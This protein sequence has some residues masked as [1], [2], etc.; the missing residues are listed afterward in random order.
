MHSLIFVCTNSKTVHWTQDTAIKNIEAQLN[1]SHSEP[2]SWSQV[3]ETFDME[4]E[5]GS[6][7]DVSKLDTCVTVVDASNLDLNLK[8]IEKVKVRPAE[9]KCSYARNRS[10][11]WALMQLTEFMTMN[12]ATMSKS[13]RKDM[14]QSSALLHPFDA[15]TIP[16]S[17]SLEEANFIQM[18]LQ[19][20]ITEAWDW[21]IQSF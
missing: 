1:S 15:A 16:R 5:G 12:W 8:S 19:S 18:A 9:D 13:I 17:S 10:L 11:E 4:L 3:A 20:Q 2:R 21:D 6:L 7:K 14:Y